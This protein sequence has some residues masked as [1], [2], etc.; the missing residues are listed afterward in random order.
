MTYARTSGRALAALAGAA[1]L[2][3]MFA[4]SPASA[5]P[6]AAPAGASDV[7]APIQQVWWDRWGYW[8]PNHRRVVWRCW[9]RA[10]APPRCGWVRAW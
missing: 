3:S 7:A 6:L 1:L 8:H 9:R 4:A 10:W 5:M 2:A